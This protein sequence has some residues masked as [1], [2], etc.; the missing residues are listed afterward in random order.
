MPTFI[1][2]I[3]KGITPGPYCL[4]CPHMSYVR[5]YL[6]PLCLLFEETLGIM[7][8]KVLRHPLCLLNIYIRNEHG[9]TY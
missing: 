9:S 3:A 7:D 2:E 6:P 1:E 4:T 8:H 5:D